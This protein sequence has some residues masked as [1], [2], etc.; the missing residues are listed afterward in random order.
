MRQLRIFVFIFM[1]AT[2]A[3]SCGAEIIVSETLLNE[4]GLETVWQ[5]SLA[6]GTNE[7]VENIWLEGEHLFVLTDINYIFC[8]DRNTGKLIISL[9]I[10]RP[11]L[12][13]LKPVVVGGIAY[14]VAGN[15]MVAIDVA[16]GVE[17]YREQINFVVAAAP[18]VNATYY[19]TP[20]IDKKLK[21]VS[22]ENKRTVF[23][24]SADD[25]SAITSVIA[26]NHFAIFSTN[27][28]SVVSMD[29]ASPKKIWQFDA[30]LAITAPL[31][32]DKQ[33]IYAASRDTNVYKIDAARGKLAWKFHTGA[34]LDTSPRV[35]NSAVYQFAQSKGLYAINAKNGKELWRLAEGSDFLAQD[36]NTAYVIDETGTCSVMDNA[37]G[38]KIRTINFLKV[39][40][41]VPNISDN[42][43]YIMDSKNNLTCIKPTK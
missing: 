25:G 42:K 19:Y 29:S 21:A 12:P 37:T 3:S 11:G 20:S 24:A 6:M 1:L 4:A 13:V 18:A 33:G 26:D 22:L 10:A 41:S 15:V 36:K 34:A 14:I 23:N 40:K 35:T 38:K 17:L 7:K 39:A 8:I 27:S 2:L 16:G 28:G 9:P 31:V 5:S 43:I 30:V 32:R